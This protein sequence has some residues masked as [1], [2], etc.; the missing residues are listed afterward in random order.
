[1]TIILDVSAAIQI[2]L[3]KEKAEFFN[4]WYKKADWIISPDL[5]ISELTNVLWKYNRAEIFDHGTCKE[6]VQDGIDL[7]DDYCESEELWVE[8]LSESIKNKHSAYDMFYAIL[9]RRN[10]ETLVS[11]DNKLVHI[12]KE[13]HIETCGNN[14]LH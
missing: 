5:Y 13:M 14:T 1:M 6:Y 12:C 7:V 9:A 4:G 10:D 8:I 3:K 11:N 2:L